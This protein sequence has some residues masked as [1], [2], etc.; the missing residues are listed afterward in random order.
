M[1]N[2]E[3]MKKTFVVVS[4]L[5]T[6]VFLYG[7]RFEEPVTDTAEFSGLKVKV[8]GDFTLQFQGLEHY[9]EVEELYDL[10]PNFNLPT[11][12]LDIDVLL[13]D[14]IRMHMR[15]YLS[16][17]HH[18]DTW[19][20]GGHI[21]VNR[22]DF[23]REGLLTEFM[24]RISIRAGLDEINYGDAHFRRTDNA[25][26]IHNPF[27][28]NFIMDAFS[29]EVF[30][31]VIIRT[32]AFIGLIGISNGKLNQHVTVTDRTNHDNRI[33]FY[34]KLG[35][36]DRPVD[37]LRIRLTG[38]WYMNRG[39][40]TGTNLYGGDRAGSRYYSVLVPEGGDDIFTGGRFNPGFLQVASF[41]ANPFVQFRGLE[42]FGIYEY[43]RG[44]EAD[45]NGSYHQAGG[46]LVY[47]FG[48]N[49][50]FYAGARYN[51]VSG[52]QTENAANRSVRRLNLGG[53]WFIT[54]RILT[55]IEYVRQDYSGEG[56]TGQRFQ[57]AWFRGMMIEGTIT[58]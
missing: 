44:G 29:T 18:N 2:S 9:S 51:L 35:Y 19:V 5:A 6:A 43:V 27:V 28:G 36:D 16:S 34:G 50:Q 54:P 47:R 3:P 8:G 13:A 53:G 12:N 33:S 10:V 26:A 15:T 23:I 25:E 49:E 48:R 55:K 38:S 22:L 40:T 58:F 21:T 4:L 42:F 7:Q 46:E 56:W 37:A 14:G 31:E 41:Q 45:G 32:G 24:H 20:K 11:A 57:G 1:K 30:G 52:R 17:R 39:T